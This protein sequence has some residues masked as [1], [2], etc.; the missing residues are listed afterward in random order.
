MSPL[1][2]LTCFP[3]LLL[4][5]CWLHS[6]LSHFLSGSCSVCLGHTP[7]LSS[8]HPHSLS[9]GLCLILSLCL[10]LGRMHFISFFRLS[11][12]AVLMFSLGNACFL[13]VLVILVSRCHALSW[14]HTL[15]LW[16]TCTCCLFGSHAL[17]FS[18]CLFF[19]VVFGLSL[20]QSY[21]LLQFLSHA[22]FF[23][24]CALCVIGLL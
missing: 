19:W 5:D 11:L 13:S 10:S 16:I 4:S 12:W 18:L 3:S 6:H 8:S 2:Q 15:S 17:S 1:L 22:H 7:P 21:A 14:A 9:L 24:G 20:G 23:R